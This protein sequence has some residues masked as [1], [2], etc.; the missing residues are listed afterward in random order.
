MGPSQA[1]RFAG[2]QILRGIALDR[3]S[4]LLGLDQCFLR[5][6]FEGAFR[7]GLLHITHS[8]DEW[9]TEVGC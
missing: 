8:P 7:P 3:G 5:W 1:V 6:L 2:C 4:G 9:M